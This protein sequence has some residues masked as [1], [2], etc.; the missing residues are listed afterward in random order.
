MP[1]SPLTPRKAV[2]REITEREVRTLPGSDESGG[3][4]PTSAYFGINTFGV[5]QMRDKLPRDAYTP[6]HER[7]G[8]DFTKEEKVWDGRPALGGALGH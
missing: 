7:C 8:V 2:I 6:R 1:A 5:R 3:H 4:G